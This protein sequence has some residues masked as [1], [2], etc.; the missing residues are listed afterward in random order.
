MEEAG[1]QGRMAEGHEGRRSPPGRSNQASRC[2]RS[3]P[4]SS[5]TARFR[6]P[7]P[8]IRGLADSDFFDRV[9]GHVRRSHL[10]VRSLQRQPD[11]RTERPDAARSAAGADHDVRRRHALPRR[12]RVCAT[13]WSARKQFGDLARRFKLGR[14][15]LVASPNDGTPLATPKRW[16]DTIGWIAN[17]LEMFP[18]NPFTTGAAF[19][20]NGLVWLANHASGDLPGSACDGRATASRS[21]RSRVRPVRP[22]DAYSALVANYQPT[23][24]VLQRLLDVGID[25]FFGVG[26]RSR[27]AVGGRLARRSADAPVSF[28]RRG[29]VASGRAATCRPDSVTHVSF[30]SQAR[31]RGLSRQRAARPAAAAE[32]RGPA[33]EPARSPAAA[34]RDG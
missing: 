27:R 20:A 9:Q 24:D 21:R 5:S 19:V 28:R 18:D 2:R 22:G 16:D 30:F 25:Q 7:R 34:R 11:A 3:V 14:A 10:R 12:S 32:R 33:Q 4:C 13:S 23:G 31:D 26:Q 1:L 15:V 29:S 6:T 8:R 17:L